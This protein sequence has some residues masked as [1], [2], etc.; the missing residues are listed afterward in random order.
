MELSKSTC[1]RPLMAEHRTD[2]EILLWER[3]SRPIV[4]N[5]RADRAGRPF[6]AQGQRGSVSVW[7]RIHLLLD[8]VC[9]RTDASCEERR[10]LE[11]G[12]TDLLVSI[13]KRPASCC[14]L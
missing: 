6:R 12:D 3:M 2:V 8:D 14:L 5:E 13:T 11:D 9:R 1:L 10:E 7:K 4:L